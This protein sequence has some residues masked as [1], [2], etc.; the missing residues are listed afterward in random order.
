MKTLVF[1]ST[2]RARSRRALSACSPRPRRW[3]AQP[4]SSSE[5]GADAAAEAGAHGAAQVF[6]ADAAQTA[7]PWRS[8]GSTCSR[9]WPSDEGSTR[10][11]SASRCWRPTSPPRSPSGSTPVSTGISSTCAWTT[12]AS[13]AS[14]RPSATASSRHGLARRRL[15]SRSS[16]R[17]A[18]IRSRRG[19]R[20]SGRS[21][22]LEELDARHAHRPRHEEQAGPSI[23]D[24]DI[25]VAGGRGSA[26]RRA[27]RSV[28]ELA[29]ALGG[30]VAA[31]RAVVDAGWY[32]YRRSW[33]RWERPWRRSSTSPAGSRGRSS[34]R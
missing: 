34:T 17:V 12:V 20:S 16:V 6:V 27:S 1:L 32:P 4:A 8:L 15:P 18:S 11:S 2:T 13:W 10:S 25:I 30:A 26:A 23:E 31:T 29:K 5:T 28:E 7:P 9:R 24:A 3:G 19:G 21:A 14:A 22:E 33:A